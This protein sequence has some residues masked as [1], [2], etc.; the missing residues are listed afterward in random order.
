ML[1]FYSFLSE[2][3]KRKVQRCGP[4][5]SERN[6]LKRSIRCCSLYIFCWRG[7]LVSSRL[8]N[9]KRKTDCS[10][11]SHVFDH[12]R[13]IQKTRKRSCFDSFED[14]FPWLLCLIFAKAQQC[15]SGWLYLNIWGCK[16]FF[17]LTPCTGFFPLSVPPF[18]S[19][20]F[21][22]LN[23]TL[24]SSLAEITGGG[25]MRYICFPVLSYLARREM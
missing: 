3:N 19:V 25:V 9:W 6:L 10:S 22:S 1:T 5:L 7:L 4:S 21:F 12:E 15:L 24:L 20:S 8:H 18:L 23:K 16:L 13:S 14:N 11:H 2:N 17:R